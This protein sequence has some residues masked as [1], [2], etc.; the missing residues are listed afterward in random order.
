MTT[1]YYKNSYFARHNIVSW[2]TNGFYFDLIELQMKDQ[3]E[4]KT[5]IETF[6][7]QYDQ[8]DYHRIADL[9]ISKNYA[10]LSVSHKI[11]LVNEI[12]RNKY[13]INLHIAEEQA[14]LSLVGSL[15]NKS[16]PG[17]IQAKIDQM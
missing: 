10:F 5:N 12:L 8:V 16:L 4:I 11:I 6:E 1:I 9:I 7:M 15:M 13:K 3:F 2:L 14:Y 17:T